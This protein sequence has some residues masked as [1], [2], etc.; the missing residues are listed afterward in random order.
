MTKIPTRVRVQIEN[1]PNYKVCA[2]I[3]H[4][5]HVCGGRVTMEHALIYAG[6]QIQEKWAIVP[7]CAKGQEVDQYQ[8]AHTMNKDLNKWVAL[9]QG[10]DD[11]F[12]MF[13]KAFPPYRQQREILNKKYGIWSR[14][15]DNQINYNLIK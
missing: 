3:G 7:I 2:L 15:Q 6:K 10:S 1:D 4:H 11:D 13:P 12:K 8:D 14:Y 5:G 9:N